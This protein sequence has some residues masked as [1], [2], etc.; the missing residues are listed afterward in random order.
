MDQGQVV[1]A[2]LVTKP[3]VQF[4]AQGQVEPGQAEYVGAVQ[5]LVA[6][7]AH[8]AVGF[9]EDQVHHLLVGEGFM[10]HHQVAVEFLLTAAQQLLPLPEQPVGQGRE[11]LLV[12]KIVLQPGAERTVGQGIGK[13]A[14]FLAGLAVEQPF[15]LLVQ[16]FVVATGLLQGLAAPEAGGLA[17]LVLTGE[18][19]P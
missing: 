11:R 1:V 5:T 17:R 19:G 16:G 3:V 7:E 6:I 15:H 14:V 12:L 18:G 4:D 13:T 8:C 10:H 9:Q 2:A